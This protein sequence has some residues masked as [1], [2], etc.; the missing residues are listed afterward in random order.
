MSKDSVE[1]NTTNNANDS[2]STT[3]NTSTNNTSTTNTNTVEEIITLNDFSTAL[4]D[5]SKGLVIIDFFT[6]WCGPCKR[7]APDYIR[8]AEKYPTVSFY[9]INAENENLSNIVAACEIVS[10]PTFCFFKGGKY[11][12]RFVNADPVGLEKSIVKSSQ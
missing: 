6:T 4:G 3:N 12:G 7:I 5:E 2:T 10:L 11:I 1:T 9:K 8:M